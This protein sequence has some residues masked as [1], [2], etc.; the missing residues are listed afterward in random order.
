MVSG[1]ELHMSQKLTLA[2]VFSL[3]L[4]IPIFDIL[5]TVES[6]RSGTFSGVALWSSL[7][8]TIAVIVASLPVYKALLTTKGRQTIMSR[9]RSQWRSCEYVRSQ[10]E[11]IIISSA[12]ESRKASIPTSGDDLELQAFESAIIGV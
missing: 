12:I 10:D 5:R 11:G 9:W 2:G 4:I 7:E 1:L 8:V 3:G 6:L